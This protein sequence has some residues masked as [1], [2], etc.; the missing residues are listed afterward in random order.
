MYKYIG[1]TVSLQIA[2]M[3]QLEK[4]VQTVAL[5]DSHLLIVCSGA[6]QALVIDCNASNSN[7]T[8]PPAQQLQTLGIAILQTAF[9][10]YPVHRDTILEDILHLLPELPSG[11]RSLRAFPVSY[12][13]ANYPS[14]LLDMNAQVVGNLVSNGSA[15]HFVQMVSILLVQLLQSCVVRPSYPED[16]QEGTTTLRSG[17][18]TS[19][20]V[21]DTFVL[22]LLKRCVKTRGGGTSE[23]RPFLSNLV[24]DFLL[25]L[26]IPEYPAAHMWLSTVQR[27]LNQDLVLL[28]PDTHPIGYWL[29]MPPKYNFPLFHL[30]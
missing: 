2:L 14:A 4:L 22:H 27:L 9:A 23:Y 30:S 29:L 8:L 17:L 16:E 10:K 28:C 5:D 24:E 15:P 25:L 3:E 20:A 6:L 18:R 19:Q 12:N 21:A 1:T 7:S 11:K 13:S 26:L